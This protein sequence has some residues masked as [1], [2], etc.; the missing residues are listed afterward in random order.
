MRAAP[1]DTSELIKQ[2]E[3]GLMKEHP[4]PIIESQQKFKQLL[5]TNGQKTKNFK[6]SSIYNVICLHDDCPESRWESRR[7]FRS[8]RGKH[9]TKKHDAKQKTQCQVVSFWTTEEK[10]GYTKLSRE[11]RL[12]DDQ[13]QYIRPNEHQSID[14]DVNSPVDE[15]VQISD[16]EFDAVQQLRPETVKNNRNNHRKRSAPLHVNDAQWFVYRNVI[17]GCTV[18]VNSVTTPR[19]VNMEFYII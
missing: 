1:L 8:F 9:W 12:V 7:N 15:L 19:S 14:I 5:S 10:D 18:D 3:Y 16:A 17:C 11:Y 2:C 6:P 13:L 4:V